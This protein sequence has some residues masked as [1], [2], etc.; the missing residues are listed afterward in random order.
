MT[1]NK[2]GNG[3]GS[4]YKRKHG[5]GSSLWAASITIGVNEEGKPMRKTYYGPTRNSVADK[6][7]EALAKTKNGTYKEPAKILVREWLDT[8]LN[9]YMK[10]SIRVTTF[11]NYEVQVRLHLKPAIGHVRLSQL[12][13]AHLQ[14][15][16]NEKLTGDRADHKQGGLSAKSVR[17]IHGVIYGALEQAK[18]EGMIIINPAD[19]VKL[20]RLE[21]PEIKFFDSDQVTVFLAA[22]KESHYFTAYYL[23]LATGLRRGELLGLRWKDVDLNARTISVNQG[24][25]RT[26]QGLVF[27]PPK[28]K[29]GKRTI[30]I[31]V[32]VAGVLK[33]HEKRQNNFREEAGSAW[34]KQL[35]FLSLMPEDNDLV[36]TNE[37]GK[38]IEPRALTRHFERLLER[39]GLPNICFHDL[40]H[41]FATLCLQQGVDMRTTSENLGHYD[42]GFTLSVY[43][44]ATTKMKQEAT[45]K[46]GALLKDCI[47]KQQ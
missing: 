31:P 29:Q 32:D 5:K 12:T 30:S 16:Y 36:F 21:K 20:P 37:I 11:E 33:F 47:L 43:A 35:T 9:D 7:N 13:T 15:L 41:T 18:K 25:V 26:K 10:N 17:I 6:L 14:K 19:S 24:L 42:P 46:I 40:R 8:W 34:Q 38:P 4:I 44:G 27:H 1:G 23:E 39:A 45:D 3:E 22:A 2:R 28:T